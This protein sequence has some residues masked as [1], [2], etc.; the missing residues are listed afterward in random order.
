VVVFYTIMGLFLETIPVFVI[1]IG[2]IYPLVTGLGYDGVWFGIFSAVVLT[3]GM[4][5]P[6]VGLSL[7]V[8]QAIPPGYKMGEVMKG[9]LPF[10]IILYIA[11]ALL[12]AFPD[13]VLWLPNKVLG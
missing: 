8:V 9:T 6:P 13:L 5:T 3:A 2:T 12:V 7:Y 4:I 1:S 11:C 10:L